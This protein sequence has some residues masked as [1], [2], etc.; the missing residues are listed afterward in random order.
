MAVSDGKSLD[1]SSLCC[2][3]PALMDSLHPS[4]ALLSLQALGVEISHPG[5]NSLHILAAALQLQKVQTH[6]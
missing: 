1:L 3:H 6:E 4:M 5:Y 2:P